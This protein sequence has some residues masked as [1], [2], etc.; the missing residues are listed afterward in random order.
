MVVA[1][2]RPET[3]LGDT[4][5]AVH[6][7]DRRWQRAIGERVMLPLMERPIPIV[8]DSYADPEMG[9][10]AVKVT[11][12]HD[13]ND[14]EI[15]IRH[16]L[17]EIQVIGFSGEMTGDA[18]PFSGM[19]RFACRKAVISALKE[20]GLLQRTEDYEHVV[21]HHDKCGTSIEP[22]PMDQWFLAMKSLAN[23][24]LPA[25]KKK[26][27]RYVPDRFR[28]YSVE[29]LENIQDW[30]ISRQ[31]W[32]G[33]RIPVWTC[34]DCGEVLVRVDA[35]AVCDACGSRSLVQDPDVLDT[36]FSSALW[37]FATMGWPEQADDLKEFHP[38]DLMI[39]G[40]DILYLWVARMIMTAVEFVDEIPFGTVLVHPTVQT[41]DGKRMSKSLGTGIDPRE[42]IERYGADATRLS[43]LYQCGSSQDVRFDADVMDNR[44]QDSP[45]TESCRNFC[46]KVWNAARFVQMNL[47]GYEL[48]NGPP[49]AI[50]DDPADR[51][52]LSQY[53]RTVFSVTKSLEAYRFDEASR[54]LY[55]F[56]W[57]AFCDWYLEIAKVRLNGS[58]RD[59]GTM[60]RCVLVHVL[61][62]SLRLLHPMAPFISE[63]LWQRLPHSGEALIVAKWPEADQSRF[64]DTAEREM[65]FIQAVVGAVRNIRGAMRV[66]PGR[67]ADV[68]LKVNSPETGDILNRFEIYLRTLARVGDLRVGADI[69]RPP[70]SASA[71]LKDVE[72]YVPLHG[73]IDLEV[74]RQRLRKEIEKLE[75]L[76]GGLDTKLSNKGFLN[77]APSEVV[78]KEKGR[79]AQ[80]LSALG[81]LNENLAAVTS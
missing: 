43:L 15:G 1:T 6:P 26:E 77:N 67:R 45:I 73:L 30:C 4:G 37:P 48:A 31:I 74:E 55:E 7:D 44:L 29:W 5:V 12:A 42:L 81:R 8:A 58:N 56:V 46:N 16:G 71:V 60:T 2:T 35:P 62:G 39:T 52:I 63:A 54:T 19:D 78:E 28:A 49:P 17:P 75:T 57:N 21:P 36:W 66:P 18:G 50:A 40:R 25:L 64:D 70:A 13:P 72:V 61:E 41:R 22:L 20:S 65:A 10:G 59:A 14:Y 9:S 3:M 68:H 76:L 34:E 79:H 11:P 32:W 38:T 24:A 23:Q 33:H 51:W 53:N 27:I 80:Y 69:V 47:D